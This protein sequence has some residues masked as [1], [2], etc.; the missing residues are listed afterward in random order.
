MAIFIT[1]GAGYIGSHTCVELLNE[2][3][4]I[5]VA[6]DLSNSS[7]ISLDRV[8]EIT[9]K[10]FPFY[11][12][13]ICDEDELSLVFEEHNLD[14]VIH[15]AGLKA[16]GESV[17]RPLTYY[18]NN[19][20]S[21]LTLC[22]VMQRYHVHK[23]VYSSSATVYRP[24]NPMPLQEDA[25]LGCT[26]PYG[27][28]K[29]MCE[30]I[31]RDLASADRNWSVVLLRYFNPI[32]AHPSGLIGEDPRD[33][34]N[35][36]M[37]YISQVAAGKRE[38]L[39]IF[40][41]DYDTPDGTGIRDYI[42]VVDLAKG[43]LAA[44]RYL[45]DYS[46]VEAINLGTGR[47][48]SV[49]EVV[50]NFEQTTGVKVPYEIAGRRAGDSARCYADPQKAKRLLGWRAEKTLEGMCKDTWRWQSANPDGYGADIDPR[51]K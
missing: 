20:V 38:K 30:Q 45:E 21:T 1:G 16:V 14:S 32:G 48:F 29:F 40:G 4:K 46:G 6:D 41:D 50:K 5:V 23:I 8:R 15:F 28:T 11:T 3:Y 49:L 26:N 18:R 13:D 37:P 2:G 44:I 22:R 34:P 27:W 25:E 17:S 10:S 7:K 51:R 36:L 33:T 42:H 24:D 31:L 47:G 9:G 19:L 39:Y 12:I 35:N 43:H